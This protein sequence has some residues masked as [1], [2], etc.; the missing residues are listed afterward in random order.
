[1]FRKLSLPLVMGLAVVTGWAV[2]P[3]AQT[4]TGTV[5]LKS[6]ERHTGTDID[7]RVDRRQVSVR[8][9]QHTQPRVDVGQVAYV[10]FGGA[11]DVNL[12]LTGSQEAVVLKDGT[13]IRGQVIEMAHEDAANATGPFLVIIRDTNGQEHRFPVARVGRVYFAGGTSSSGTTGSTP[14]TAGGIVVSGKQPWTSTGIMVRRGERLTFNTTGE[15]RVGG[16]PE[17]VAP[18]AGVTGGR[19]AAG[20]PIPASI[21]GALIGRV[22][23]GQPFGIGNQTSVPMPAAGMLFLGI[24]DNNFADNSGEFRV[25]ITRSGGIRR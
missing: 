5:V 16:G 3:A 11:P 2:S 4:V 21:V 25:E 18:P 9:G 1:M 20:T 17:D 23:N 6:G 15:V 7:Y 24:N 14:S 8:T 22:G 13:V 19:T 12:N 10:D